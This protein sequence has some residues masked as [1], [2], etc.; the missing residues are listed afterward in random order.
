MQEL[1]RLGMH[2]SFGL[3]A[4][5]ESAKFASAELV[6]DRFGHDRSG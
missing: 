5:A 4:G 6:Q 3:A 1:Q 2:P